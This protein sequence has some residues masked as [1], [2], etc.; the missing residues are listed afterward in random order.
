MA[1]DIDYVAG[2]DFRVV[3]LM[4]PRVEGLDH[5]RRGD[6]VGRAW[7]GRGPAAHRLR[8]EAGRDE[9]VGRGVN[10]EVFHDVGGV[11]H[12]AATKGRA[13]GLDPQRGN[14]GSLPRSRSGRQRVAAPR[15]E[16][17]AAGR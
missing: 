3:Q 7:L 8:V 1:M 13:V 11:F 5:H 14:Y 4:P 15:G 17:R 10:V 6:H 2:E 16:D 12:H 9:L